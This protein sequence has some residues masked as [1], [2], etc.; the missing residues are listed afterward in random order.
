M[1]R[2]NLKVALLALVLT[3]VYLG[4][5]FFIERDN[6]GDTYWDRQDR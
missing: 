4:W 3:L 2:A 1:Q 6:A 5:A